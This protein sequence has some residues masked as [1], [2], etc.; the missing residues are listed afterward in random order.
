MNRL[1]EMTSS[2]MS[3]CGLRRWAAGR[4]AGVKASPSS[5]AVGWRPGCEQLGASLPSWRDHRSGRQSAR[6]TEMIWSPCWQPWLW[7]P[8]GEQL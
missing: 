4:S 5:K 8:C 6:S 1:T 3:S 2:A 7:P